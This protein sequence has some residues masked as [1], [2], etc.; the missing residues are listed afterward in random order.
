MGRFQ[1]PKA[2]LQFSGQPKLTATSKKGKQKALS[3]FMEASSYKSWKPFQFFCG[4]WLPG[5]LL[6]LWKPNLGMWVRDLMISNIPPSKT[7][8][9]FPWLSGFFW[10]IRSSFRATS[11]FSDL[12][13]DPEDA[14]L[15][16]GVKKLD[17]T[18]TLPQKKKVCLAS[19]SV[20]TLLTLLF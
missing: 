12:P 6:V 13:W 9:D 15:I 3:L 11:S 7:N 14:L 17:R 1:G 18:S 19:L 16:L 10:L 2:H 20:L 5:S 4:I 8:G